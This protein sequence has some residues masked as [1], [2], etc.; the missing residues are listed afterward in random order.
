MVSK[1]IISAFGG[2][3]LSCCLATQ[4]FAAQTLSDNEMDNVTA[5]QATATLDIITFA[6]AGPTT[7]TVTASNIAVT[8]SQVGG[9][10][11]ASVASVTA[12]LTSTAQ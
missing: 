3:A 7:A 6:A 2:L 8:A 4:S 12:T 11:P 5:G 1:M 9:L 10:T